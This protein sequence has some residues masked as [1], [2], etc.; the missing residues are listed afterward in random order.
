M[1]HSS[2]RVAYK[3]ILTHGNGCVASSRQECGSSAGTVDV[4]LVGGLVGDS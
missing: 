4:G 2:D 3:Y 1:R